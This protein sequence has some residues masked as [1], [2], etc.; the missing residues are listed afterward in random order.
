MF[1]D[2]DPRIKALTDSKYKEFRDWFDQRL[3][4]AIAAAEAQ[5]NGTDKPS[6]K[7]ILIPNC[8]HIIRVHSSV[9][10]LVNYN[11]RKDYF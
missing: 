1:V 3:D 6:T 8:F 10:A 4:D 11:C 9:K 2:L 5:E 7:G